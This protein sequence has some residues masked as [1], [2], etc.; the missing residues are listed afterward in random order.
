MTLIRND[1]HLLPLTPAPSGSPVAP[2]SGTRAPG[3]KI[4]VITFTDSARSRLGK[5]FDREMAARNPSARIFHFYNDLIGSDAGPSTFAFVNEADTVVIAPFL[6]H[7]APRQLPQSGKLTTAVGFSG[8]GAQLFSDLLAAAPEKTIIVA[9]GSPYLIEDFTSIRN[10]ICTY[11]LAST[12]EVSAV[13]ALYGE[14]QNRAKLP[15]NLPGI[16]ARGASLAWPKSRSASLSQAP[17]PL[18]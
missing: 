9:L 3:K 12:A 6:T 13:K 5:V 7:I 17:T 15:I 10:Y 11:S 16:A 2:N 1:G 14:I 8:P 18:R 4:V